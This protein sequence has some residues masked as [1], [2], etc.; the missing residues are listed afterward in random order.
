MAG[1]SRQKQ[2]IAERGIGVQIRGNGNSVIVYAGSAELGLTRK[3]LR[4]AEP[5]TE[6]QLFRVDLRATTLVGRD[7]DLSALKEWLASDRLVSVRCITGRAGA[8]KTRLAIELCEHAERAGWTAGFAQYEQFPEFVK[9][10]AEWRWNKPTLA[11]IDYAASL[12]QGLRTWLEILVRPEAQTGS[13]K[14]RC[15]LLE[16]HAERDLGWWADLMR[17]VSFSDPAPDELA[18]PPEPVPLPSLNAVEDRRRL[19]AEAMRSAGQMASLQPI[20]KPPPPGANVDFDRRLGD[21]TINN[22]PLYLMMAGA[23]AIRSGAP[24]ALALT[25]TDLAERAASRER[26]RLNRLALQWGVSDKLVAHLAICV[27]LQGGC[28]AEEALQLISEEWHA[29]GFPETGPAAD[30]VERLGEAL[31][32]PGGAPVDAVRPDLIGEAFLLQGMQ[33]LR[34]FPAVQTEIINRAWRRVDGRVATTLI[35][36]AQDYARGDASHCSVVWLRHVLDQIDDFAALIALNAE[37]PQ[38][39]VALRELAAAAEERINSILAKAATTEPELR[40]SVASAR[41]SLAARLSA[42]GRREPAL[43]AA[44]EAV[45]IRRELAGQRPDAFRPDLAASLNSL[46]NRLSALGRRE[47]ALAAAE[48]AV[49]IR[50]ELAGQR[51]DAFRPDLAISLNNLAAM[52]SD[53]GRREP[54]LA[55]AEEAVA[56]RREL[57]GQRPDAFRPDLAMSLNNLAN[58]L[59]DLGRREPALAAAEEAAALYRELAGQRPDA[60]RP[61]LAR[62]LHTLAAML[63]ALGRREPALAAAEEAVAI[64]RE[65]A[66]QRPD[67]FRPDLAMSLHNLAAMLSALGRREP[68]LAAAEEAV[69]IRRELAGQ[70]PDAFRPDLA[71]SLSNLA[72]LLSTLG[73]REPALA[74]AE[75]AAALYRELAGQRPEAFR[76][77]LATSLAVRAN[78]LDALGRAADALATNVE[79]V[80]MLS[81]AFVEHP[82]A[83]GHRMAHIIRQYLERCERI[84]QQPDTE[85]LGPVVAILQNQHTQTEE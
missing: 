9:R 79:A 32:M 66:G 50:R 7:R 43:A 45:A 82:A 83:F 1:M 51:P 58:M 46:A 65:L 44:E 22:E 14:L 78:C 39:T 77:D 40:R 53:L 37:I 68:A 35:R 49:A 59:S 18:D 10:A 57:A 71:M 25:R 41:N 48:E 8:G 29:M 26:E 2:T 67:A 62:S 20:P 42:L 69:A 74:A 24:A 80:T 28:S 64:R 81:E 34:N 31:P 16:R 36:T 30:L 38:Q 12:A 4:Q 27:T 17:T 3:H 11:V 73:R 54:A 47:P 33:Q 52:L 72:N 85:L 6:L 61:D 76:P 13:N 56:I 63:S 55:A 70:R 21:D 84:G 19:L 60:F 15:L 5:K 75:E 23:E